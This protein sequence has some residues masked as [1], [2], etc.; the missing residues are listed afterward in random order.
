MEDANRQPLETILLSCAR[1]APDPWY[2][3]AFADTA[4]IP[5]EQLDGW[6]DELRLGGL[7]RLTDWVQGRGQGYVLTPEGHAVV[8]NPRLLEKVDANGVPRKPV[9][10]PAAAPRPKGGMD[11]WERGETIRAALL[12]PARPVV[13]HVLIAVNVLVFLA[14]VA[15]AQRAQMPLSK[16]LYGSHPDILE[17]TGAVSPVDVL[18]GQWWRLLTSCFVHVGLLHLGMNMYGLYILGPLVERLFGHWRYL[19]LYLIAGFGGDCIGVLLTPPTV[20]NDGRLLIT[21]LAGAS[22][23][24]CGLLGAIAAWTYLNRRSLPPALVA[25]WFRVVLLNAVLIAIISTLPNIS[26]SGHLGGAVVG[27]MTAGLL[28]YQRFGVTWQ[29][30]LAALCLV[31]LPLICY[32]ALLR[33]PSFDKRWAEFSR[34]YEVWKVQ[35]GA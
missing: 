7:I 33:A 22:G 6:L 9:A 13:T 16:F 21:Q 14:G 10:L 15:L 5:R 1:A 8:N 25:T 35:R 34:A 18:E 20:S 30:L 19:V 4:A 3:A 29:R 28:N 26:W 32:V 31:L 17:A 11:A 27:L 23:A 12:Y 24:L 2:P